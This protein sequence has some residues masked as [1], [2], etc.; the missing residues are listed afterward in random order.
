[1]NNILLMSIDLG[2]SFVKAGIY[3]TKGNCIALVSEPVSDERPRPG[4]F[5]QHG[6]E[7]FESVVRCIKKATLSID[8]RVKDIEAMAF[9]GQMAG[10]MGVDK[11]WK[12]I[13][14]WSCSLDTRYVPYA[15]R[16][17]KKYSAD[18]L[19]ISGT[20]SP[21]MAPKYEWFMTEFPDESKKIAK[22]MMISSYIIGRLGNLP[23]EEA[24]I[25]RSFITWT[26]L[27]DIVNCE[28]SEKLC[29]NFGLD[30][31][32][33][34]RIVK[35]NDIC[36]KLSKEMADETGLRAGIPLVSGAGD[37]VAGNV[38][39]GILESGE[40]IFEA[41]SYGAVSCM[42][43]EYKPNH[44][45]NYYDAIASAI[46]GKLYAHHYIPGSG[47]TLDWF[48]NNF[49]NLS[50]IDKGKAFNELDKK[51]E[52]L[53]IGSDGVMAIGLLGGSAMPFD[54]ALRGS[55]MGYTWSHKPEHFYR[56]L[57]E[58]F[59]YDLA[60]TMDS[61]SKMYPEYALDEV[62]I[63]G[64][65]AK[66]KVWTQMLAD[67]TGK[68]FQKLNRDD[69]ALWGAAILAGTGIGV[70]NDIKKISKQYIDICD[71]YEP[72]EKRHDNYQKYKDLYYDFTKEFHS[73]YVKLEKLKI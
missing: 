16:Q 62:K 57:L 47:I 53:P 15:D 64:G 25:D 23:I 45:T 13:T 28:W 26:G 54:G 48:I 63:I 14:T 8:D 32:Y 6:E 34:P 72:D 1:M 40:M 17:M 65:G 43:D 35:S 42:I 27:A 69:T 73:Y 36:A 55:W 41:A 44:Q 59:S 7:L 56:A 31:K 10:F 3:N 2:T 21:L 20:N 4:V 58:S 46:D 37:K 11:D 50:G 70:F 5:I 19:N 22:Y 51:V 12:D 29:D 9:T 60:I 33:L 18:F 39:A 49:I 67:V 71:T 61:I 52:Q 24:V 38:G 66:S 30:R 68:T